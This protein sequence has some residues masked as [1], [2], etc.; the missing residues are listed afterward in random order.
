M[1]PWIWREDENVSDKV[2]KL[3]QKKEKQKQAKEQ[4]GREEIWKKI[5]EKGKIIARNTVERN[6]CV[7]VFD[8]E[9]DQSKGWNVETKG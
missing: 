3:K 5:T 6:K 2:K 8:G 1:R 9:S 7:V 4:Q